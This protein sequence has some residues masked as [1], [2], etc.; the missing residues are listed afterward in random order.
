METIK[1]ILPWIQIILSILLIV[2]VLLQ[3]TE[4]GLGAGFGGS[5]ESFAQTRRGF[6][7]TLL[8]ATI[9]LGILFALT[10]ILALFI[11]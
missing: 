2:V 3:R 6:E 10:S 8:H 5:G 1:T 4:A 7:K 11:R 9:V